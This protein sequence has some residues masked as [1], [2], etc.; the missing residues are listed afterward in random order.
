MVK[1]VQKPLAMVAINFPPG[2]T[3][4]T[5]TPVKSLIV[6]A[7]AAYFEYIPPTTWLLCFKPGKIALAES[8]VATVRELRRRDG[9]FAAIGAAARVGIVVYESDFFGRVR[10]L[11]LGDE[12]N[13]VLRAASADATCA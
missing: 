5:F 7:R 9:C 4:E 11:P 12:V 3:K 8:L 13:F 2:F 6:A 1:A 10:S